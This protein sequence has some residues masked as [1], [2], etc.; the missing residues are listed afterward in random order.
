VGPPK[1]GAVVLAEFTPTSK[2]RF[3]LLVTQNYGHGR[4]ALLATSGTWRWQ[5]LQDHTDMSHEMFWQQM[6]RWLVE[7]TPGRV[8]GTTPQPVVS[9]DAKVHLQAQVHDKT[10]SW[11]NDAKVEAHI[12]G[13]NGEA[14][15]AELSLEP[16]TEGVYS[17]DWAAPRS[18]SYLAEIVAR[19]GTEEIGRDVVLFRREDGVAENFHAEQNRE[20]LEKLAAE[21]GGKYYRPDDLARLTRD[22]SFSE[23]GITVRETRDLWDMP[24]I[25]LLALALRGGEWLLRRRWGVV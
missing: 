3:P 24:A 20:L 19:R 25:F 9:D 21:T 7:D 5:M 14:S 13:P 18:G 12:L 6:L 1:P 2:G 16:G 15:D 10:Y 17:M 8:S 4:V 11:L 22:V 23:A